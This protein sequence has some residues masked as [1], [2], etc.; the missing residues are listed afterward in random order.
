[1]AATNTDVK[2]FFALTG[3]NPNVTNAQLTRLAAA[4]GARVNQDGTPADAGQ[5]VDFIY[6]EL[7]NIT[8]YHEQD[9]A[10]STARAGVAF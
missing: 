6:Q 1:M 3:N 7:K 9:A 5:L 10:A 8:I 4:V 2:N